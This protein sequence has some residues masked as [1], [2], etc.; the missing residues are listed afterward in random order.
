[1][2]KRFAKMTDGEKF[3]RLLVRGWKEHKRAFQTGQMVYASPD[4]AKAYCALGCVAAELPTGIVAAEHLRKAFPTFS[5][6]RLLEIAKVND[7]C[8]TKNESMRKVKAL[9]REQ[10]W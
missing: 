5:T 10:G 6:E 2:A 9:I 8:K 1:M 4:G 7:V 3:I